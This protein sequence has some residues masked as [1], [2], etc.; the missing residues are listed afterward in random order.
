VRRRHKMPQQSRM[1]SFD[2]LPPPP[3]FFSKKG[4][5]P[6]IFIFFFNREK[7]EKGEKEIIAMVT[8]TKVVMTGAGAGA[9]AGVYFAEEED[10]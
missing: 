4:N 10:S 6:A 9:G 5:F 1:T 3:L 8:K 7:G 2:F